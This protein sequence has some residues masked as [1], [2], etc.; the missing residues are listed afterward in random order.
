VIKQ[1]IEIEFNRINE[2]AIELMK[3]LTSI[4][5]NKKKLKRSPQKKIPPKWDFEV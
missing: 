4:L 2:K 3:L 1:C 5:K